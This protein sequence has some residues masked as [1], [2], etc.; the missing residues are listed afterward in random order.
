MAKA[1]LES[2]QKL[3]KIMLYSSANINLAT[4]LM[5]LKSATQATIKKK[6]HSKVIKS[7]EILTW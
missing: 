3:L 5:K 1:C 7:K 4:F 2:F 6:Q